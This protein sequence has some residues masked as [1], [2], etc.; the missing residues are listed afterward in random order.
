MSLSIILFYPAMLSGECLRLDSCTQQSRTQLLNSE[1]EILIDQ[2]KLKD[3]CEAHA[4][5]KT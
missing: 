1:S 2:R 5:F 3:Q 4:A